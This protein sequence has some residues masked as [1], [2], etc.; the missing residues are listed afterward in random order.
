MIFI[1]VALT[2]VHAK[3]AAFDSLSGREPCL[4]TDSR[5]LSLELDYGSH[6]QLQ[7]S[8]TELG[9]GFVSDR[10]VVKEKRP[11]LSLI[12]EQVYR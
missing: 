11:D 3:A 2:K 10:L 7:S 8:H 6:I 1:A 4:E 9:T 5:S 12:G